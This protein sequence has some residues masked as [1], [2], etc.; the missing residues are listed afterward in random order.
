MSNKTDIAASPE[1]VW[2][3]KSNLVEIWHR[4]K[5]NKV[6]VACLFVILIVP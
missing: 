3:K 5:K 4:L 6:A 1:L 2:K